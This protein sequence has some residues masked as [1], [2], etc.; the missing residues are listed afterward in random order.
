MIPD[1][2][3]PSIEAEDRFK[4]IITGTFKIPGRKSGILLYGPVGVGKTMAAKALP[5]LMEGR[6]VSSRFIEC[7]SGRSGI[8]ESIKNTISLWP[9][10]GC[11]YNYIIL[12]EVDLLS[13]SNGE[14]LAKPMNGGNAVFIM[15]TNNL[16]DVSDKVKSRSVLINCEPS[17]PAQ[18]IPAIQDKYQKAGITVDNAFILQR[19]LKGRADLRDALSEAE[20]DILGR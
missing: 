4:K 8:V 18:W 2:Y 16:K 7:E 9:L 13:A 3:Y 10:D 20:I 11:N 14:D 19:I 6:P 17:S 15:T 1:F 5:A 12:D